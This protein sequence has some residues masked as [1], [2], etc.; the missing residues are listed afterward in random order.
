[1]IQLQLNENER[2]ILVELLETCISDLRVEITGTDSLDY[3]EMLKQKKEV[4]MKLQQ[5]L[6]IEQETAAMT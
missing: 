1:M 6:L 2:A 3:K 4:L 5:A